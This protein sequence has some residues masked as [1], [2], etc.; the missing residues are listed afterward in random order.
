MPFPAGVNFCRTAFHTAPKSRGQ[1][2]ENFAVTLQT[3]RI[4]SWSLALESGRSCWICCF[5]IGLHSVKIHST[6]WAWSFLL[7]SVCS[8]IHSHSALQ[9]VFIKPV[10]STPP[11]LSVPAVQFLGRLEVVI[12]ERSAKVGVGGW[13]AIHITSALLRCNSHNHTSTIKIWGFKIKLVSAGQMLYHRKKT[14]FHKNEIC[15]WMHMAYL[16]TEHWHVWVLLDQHG[17]NS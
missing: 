17:N 14:S 12:S 8:N 9:P 2:K 6:L 16:V 4:K 15:I 11:H 5:T 7:Q 13:E 10:H 3:C 1:E